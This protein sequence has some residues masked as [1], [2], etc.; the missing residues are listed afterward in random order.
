[1]RVMLSPVLTGNHVLK[2]LIQRLLLDYLASLYFSLTVA[3][4]LTAT[5]S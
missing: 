3:Y 1:M 2:V 5:P 4:S